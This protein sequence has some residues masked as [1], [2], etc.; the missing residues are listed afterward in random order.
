MACGCISSRTPGARL[1]P[2]VRRGS[3]RCRRPSGIVRSDCAAADQG[4]AV[5]RSDRRL[6]RRVGC[7]PVE[8]VHRG[9]AAGPSAGPDRTGSGRVG[10]G[11]SGN[12]PR[13]RWPG[14]AG[15]PDSERSAGRRCRRDVGPAGLR[16]EPCCR[17]DADRARRLGQSLPRRRRRVADEWPRCQGK[18]RRRHISRIPSDASR[19][20]A[21]GP[22]CGNRGLARRGGQHD[23][24]EPTGCAAAE[25]GHRARAAVAARDAVGRVV[26]VHQAR[27]GD[28]SADNP[29]R[30]AHV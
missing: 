7:G 8:A 25:H 3:R 1:Q 27:R 30:G 15:G 18:G 23:R 20:R 5:A 22:V 2:G 9:R 16:A 6:A 26:H 19:T 29:D 24:H 11:L 28:D 10:A 14:S 4:I 12:R 21:R 17:A 13:G